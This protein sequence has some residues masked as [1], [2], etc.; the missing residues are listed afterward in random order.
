MACRGNQY[1]GLQ[2]NWKNTKITISLK[3]LLQ[4]F[5]KYAYM[6]DIFICQFDSVEFSD[7]SLPIFQNILKNYFVNQVHCNQMVFK[8]LAESAM[9]QQKILCGQR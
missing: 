1:G 6:L 3:V 5:L 2:T 4:L 7:G 9:C 8:R